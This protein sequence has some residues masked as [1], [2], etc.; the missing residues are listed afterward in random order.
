MEV[1]LAKDEITRFDFKEEGAHNW[2]LDH[3]GYRVMVRRANG[4][5]EITIRA[6]IDRDPTGDDW[7]KVE[8]SVNAFYTNLHIARHGDTN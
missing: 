4:T 8:R 1:V 7:I 5:V 2:T 3:A 6:A